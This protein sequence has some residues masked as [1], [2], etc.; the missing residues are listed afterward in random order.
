MGSSLQIRDHRADPRRRTTMTGLVSVVL[1]LL[2]IAAC[3]GSDKKAATSSSAS[4]A[5]RSSSADASDSD[6]FSSKAASTNSVTGGGDGCGVT[7]EDVDA[8]VGRNVVEHQTP[9]AFRCNFTWE[10][11]GN[12]GIDV[13]RLAGRRAD[14]EGATNQVPAGDQKLGDGT[15]YESVD[16]GEQA[17]AYGNAKTVTVVAVRGNDLVAVDVVF[18]GTPPAGERTA[19]GLNSTFLDI[20]VELAKKALG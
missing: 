1:C 20:C 6:T 15:P 17:W 10:D 19:L 4:S 18:D 14:F 13:A 5:S 2:A 7:E 9:D 11:N 8:A 3:G 12:Y 16:V